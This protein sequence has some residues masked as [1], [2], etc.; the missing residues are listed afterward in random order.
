MRGG[1]FRSAPCRGGPHLVT[2]KSM[3]PITMHQVIT[4]ARRTLGTTATSTRFPRLLTWEHARA[5]IE[6][7][8]FPLGDGSLVL[9]K[10]WAP[11][12]HAWS[13]MTVDDFGRM[14][15]GSAEV[16]PRGYVFT[17]PGDPSRPI[18]SELLAWLCEAERDHL[19]TLYCVAEAAIRGVPEFHL[20]WYNSAICPA[21][22]R[23]LDWFGRHSTYTP[24]SLKV[25]LHKLRYWLSAFG[26]EGITSPEDPV[27]WSWVF[28]RAG[29]PP[30]PLARLWEQWTSWALEDM[31]IEVPGLP[32]IPEEVIATF[33][34]LGAAG[35]FWTDEM[36]ERAAH[37]K[38]LALLLNWA[39]AK[40]AVVAT[41]K[42]TPLL[43]R[44]AGGKDPVNRKDPILERIWDYPAEVRGIKERGSWW[45]T[46][47]M[48]FRYPGAGA[49]TEATTHRAQLVPGAP[50]GRPVTP[51]G[52]SEGEVCCQIVIPR[53]IL[54]Q[55]VEFAE[56]L[57]AGMDTGV[58]PPAINA[59][60]FTPLL[61]ENRSPPEEKKKGKGEKVKKAPK[62]PKKVV[63]PV[64][65]VEEPAEVPA[66]AAAIPML[67]ADL[68]AA[69]AIAAGWDR[70]SWLAVYRR[71]PGCPNPFEVEKAP[72]EHRFRNGFKVPS[73]W[74]P[75]M[76]NLWKQAGIITAADREIPGLDAYSDI[77]WTDAGEAE[78][79]AAEN[80]S[81]GESAH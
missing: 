74:L 72:T 38:G 33:Q 35:D 52:V 39:T 61:I 32:G 31:G 5:T 3:K 76:S 12:L 25:T 6:G 66:V 55:V 23:F 44:F 56:R 41:P 49:P 69:Q 15:E 65:D 63:A 34:K 1:D 20:P 10:D 37:T 26:P 36:L 28:G 64:P 47:R 4:G 17:A 22:V 59:A 50:V 29:T 21:A 71:V 48:L 2:G 7:F 53:R 67:V 45:D 40:G 68:P 51:E 58:A 70:R 81:V 46:P 80:A 27:A 9:P 13:G 77:F 78:W 57:L 62:A 18:S 43:P 60:P 16:S 42:V 24:G 75:R 54:V 14:G 11:V 79:D 30:V 8:S 73:E 19:R